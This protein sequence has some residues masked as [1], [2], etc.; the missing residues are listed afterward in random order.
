MGK[1]NKKWIKTAIKHPGALRKTAERHGALKNGI[2]PAWLD[3]AASGEGVS[4][5]TAQRA[6]LAKTLKK[7][8]R[9]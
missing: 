1:E 4:K 8:R 5:K 7:V 9:K 6:R 2:D 3:K